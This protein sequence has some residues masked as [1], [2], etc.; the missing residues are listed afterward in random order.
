MFSTLSK[1]APKCLQTATS[2]STLILSAALTIQDSVE[3]LD[4]LEPQES[5]TT[6]NWAFL[7]EANRRLTDISGPSF[8]SISTFAFKSQSST[9]ASAAH[10]KAF[11]ASVPKL[12]QLFN[13]PKSA[14]VISNLDGLAT[15]ILDM[16]HFLDSD[17]VNMKY[18]FLGL[19]TAIR[20][21]TLP[22]HSYKSAFKDG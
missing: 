15:D 13:L 20:D 3:S 18:L 8:A 7:V 17:N 22:R 10:P 6:K 2:S 5:F 14:L 12:R 9:F 16:L 1:M 4:V 11:Y 19:R 21:S